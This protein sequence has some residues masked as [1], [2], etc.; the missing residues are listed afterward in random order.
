MPVIITAYQT[1][2][3]AMMTRIFGVIR[4]G[5]LWR[6]SITCRV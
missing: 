1:E 5:G 3:S 4:L 6:S 2:K